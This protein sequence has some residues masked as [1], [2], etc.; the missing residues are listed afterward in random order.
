MLTG[1]ST[2]RFLQH[3]HNL[4]ALSNKTYPTNHTLYKSGYI[5]KGLSLVVVSNKRD[6]NVVKD[7]KIG[8]TRIKICDDYCRDKQPEVVQATLDRIALRVGEHL[9]IQQSLSQSHVE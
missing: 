7:F 5:V 1:P 9:A 2:L 3:L 4:I 6:G 8:N